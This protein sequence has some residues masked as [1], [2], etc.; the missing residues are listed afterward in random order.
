[1]SASE[2]WDGL[3]RLIAE[4]WP[5]VLVDTLI[6]KGWAPE[7][8]RAALV[9]LVSDH[10]SEYSEDDNEWDTYCVCGKWLERDNYEMPNHVSAV[11]EDSGLLTPGEPWNL[12]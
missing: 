2:Y 11:L 8:S 7:T 10:D 5:S 12:T 1:M 3:Q 9:E 4:E 6:E